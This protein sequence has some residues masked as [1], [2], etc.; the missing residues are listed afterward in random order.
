LYLTLLI[1]TLK[2]T[3]EKQSL[4]IGNSIGAQADAEAGLR[5]ADPLND[6]KIARNIEIDD[7]AYYGYRPREDGNLKQFSTIDWS[8]KVSVDSARQRRLE[9][10]EGYTELSQ[11]RDNMRINGSSNKDIADAISDLRNEHRRHDYIKNND[12]KGLKALDSRNQKNADYYRKKGFTD[13]QI[14]NSALRNNEGMDVVVDLYKK[15]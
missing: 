8:N 3:T 5:Y 12:T 9:Y 13:E 11:L 2:V 7:S 4:D 15:H 14:I 10:L 6:P 1:S